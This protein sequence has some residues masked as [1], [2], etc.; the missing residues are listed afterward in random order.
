MLCLLATIYCMSGEQGAMFGG[1]VHKTP[2]CTSPTALQNK[3]TVYIKKSTS[4]NNN[5]KLKLK[6]Y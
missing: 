1:C 3:T 2:T 5:K 6:K 4:F